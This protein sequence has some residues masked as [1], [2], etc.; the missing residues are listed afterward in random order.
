MTKSKRC[1]ECG[2]KNIVLQNIKGASFPYKS[3]PSVELTKDLELYVCDECK[4]IIYGPRD[5]SRLDQAIESTI[6]E[7]SKIFIENI[8]EK[9]NWNQVE[10]ADYLGFSKVYISEVKNCKKVLEYKTYCYLKVLSNCQGAL[11]CA[12]SGD[13]RVT[14]THDKKKKSYI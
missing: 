8:L 14:L 11:E 5:V 9:T 2:S 10:M 12:C 3:F 7:Q 13:P 6:Q 4:N 1:G